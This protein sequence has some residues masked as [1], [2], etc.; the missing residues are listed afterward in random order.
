MIEHS[1]R[2]AAPLPDEAPDETPDRTKDAT[3]LREGADR[4]GVPLTPAQVDTFRRYHRELER[5]NRRANLTSVADWRR[6]QAVHYLDSLSVLAAIPPALLRSGRLADVGSGAGLPGIALRIAVPSLR[7]ALVE[8]TRKKADFLRGLGE[9]LGLDGVE[10]LACRAETLG[11]DPAAREAF[12]V[13]TAR[14]VA[15]LNALAELTLPLC[16]VGGVV[17][18]SKGADAEAEAAGAER[19][20]R[21]LGGALREV[22][23]VDVP[24]LD[25][26][27]ALVV[28]DKVAP[29]PDRYPRRPGIPGKRPL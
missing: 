28:L 24:G 10:V 2:V 11:R 26:P 12:D 9:S 20:V 19:A 22:R 4:L 25:R 1:R 15:R 29:T 16:R 6:A 3:A 21:T 18:A 23:R 13:V 27:R 7:V 17:V 8:A 5:G 14:G